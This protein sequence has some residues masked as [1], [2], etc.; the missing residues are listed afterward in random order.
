MDCVCKLCGGVD[1]QHHIIRDC[2]HK[3][4]AA[5]RRSPAQEAQEVSLPGDSRLSCTLWNAWTLP[6]GLVRN[7][8][9]IRPGRVSSTNA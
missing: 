2:N 9:R 6:F 3:D 4:M 5:C 1:S 8:G 7:R